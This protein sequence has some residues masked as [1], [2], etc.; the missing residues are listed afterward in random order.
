M[1]GFLVYKLKTTNTWLRHISFCKDESEWQQLESFDVSALEWSECSC[2]ID[3]EW[4][5]IA[6][7]LRIFESFVV[8]VAKSVEFT[9][10]Y[11]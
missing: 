3:F 8:H 11:F 4:S 2:S 7:S 10:G 5:K 6:S 9:S 1:L